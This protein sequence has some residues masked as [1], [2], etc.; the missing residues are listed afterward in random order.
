MMIVV[1]EVV[2][3]DIE[4]GAPRHVGTVDVVVV[5]VMSALVEFCIE[6]NGWGGCR[7]RHSEL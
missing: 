1:V 3:V 7:R 2:L 4:N 5:V 6:E